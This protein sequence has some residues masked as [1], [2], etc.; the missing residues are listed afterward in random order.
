M[1][2]YAKAVAVMNEETR[3]IRERELVCPKCHRDNSLSVVNVE[4]GQ[5]GR[6]FC[7]Q[8]SHSWDVKE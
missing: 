6:G 3:R 7:N 8:C 4:L 1:G 5:D 2:E